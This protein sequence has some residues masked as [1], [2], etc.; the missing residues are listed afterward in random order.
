MTGI[1]SP[2]ST[3]RE[4][5]NINRIRTVSLAPKIARPQKI[6]TIFGTSFEVLMGMVG[7]ALS[8]LWRVH[9]AP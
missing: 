8:N 6:I 2:D 1:R 7:L 4:A 9:R 3:T 5:I